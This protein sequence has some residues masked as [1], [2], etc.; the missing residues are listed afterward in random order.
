MK[1]RKEWVLINSAPLKS[2]K[3]FCFSIVTIFHFR[4]KNYNSPEDL[5]N[6]HRIE[7]CRDK[8]K[9]LAIR[10]VRLMRK[11]LSTSGTSNSSFLVIKY[12]WEGIHKDDCHA[13]I[14]CNVAVSFYSSTIYNFFFRHRSQLV[15]ESLTIVSRNW[16]WIIRFL[17]ARN[18]DWHVK[19]HLR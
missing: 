6:L 5:N 10:N 1:D 12:N 3:E 18:R 9:R 11:Y 15:F 4:W 17:E 2:S 8:L 7:A 13:T 14:R 19:I 16:K